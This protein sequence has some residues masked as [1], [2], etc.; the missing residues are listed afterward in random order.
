M[1]KLLYL[2]VLVGVIAASTAFSQEVVTNGLYSLNRMKETRCFVASIRF[3]VV[4][5]NHLAGYKVLRQ[6]EDATAGTE[7]LWYNEHRQQIHLWVKLYPSISDAE[8]GALS[9]LNSQS[10]VYS[11]GSTSGHA[12]GDPVNVTFVRGNALVS[13][14]GSDAKFAET[15]AEELDADILAGKNGIELKDH[16]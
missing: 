9:L 5:T 8:N 1:K 10:A 4:R 12:I 2:S 16:N 11:K 13:V 7:V 15:F 3:D 6:A 14:F